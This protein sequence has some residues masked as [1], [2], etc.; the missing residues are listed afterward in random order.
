MGKLK[1]ID[2]EQLL[3]TD[4]AL[5]IEESKKYIAHTVNTTLS[6]LYWKI[7]KRINLEVFNSLINKQ[8][9]K[10]AAVLKIDKKMTMH[11]SRHSFGQIAGDKIA[12]QLLQ[13]LYRHSDLK[14]TIGYQSNFIHK[15][16]DGAL[17]DV[18]NF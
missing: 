12:P 5:L 18:L 17:S 15:D 1:K 11:I 14:T 9:N 6:I 3:F 8:L 7:G 4:V 2:T 13:K 16:V 10:L